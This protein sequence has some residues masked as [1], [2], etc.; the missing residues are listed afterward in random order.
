MEKHVAHIVWINTVCPEAWVFKLLKWLERT[1]NANIINHSL[2]WE[3][4]F[5]GHGVFQFLLALY[6]H[7]ST[8]RR[9]LVIEHRKNIVPEL[10]YSPL[11]SN[12]NVEIGDDLNVWI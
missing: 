6:I 5:L 4:T 7:V 8:L 9:D 10:T 2:L 1:G 11:N 12:K 3:S